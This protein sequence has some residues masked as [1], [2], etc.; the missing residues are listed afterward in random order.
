M[1][2]RGGGS[3]IRN[4]VGFR[5]GSAS[6]YRRLAE[7]WCAVKDNLF[8]VFLCAL[9]FLAVIQDFAELHQAALDDTA[10]L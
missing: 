4:I 7:W 3:I 2:L 9:L 5:G 10:H 1:P 6:S 8:S